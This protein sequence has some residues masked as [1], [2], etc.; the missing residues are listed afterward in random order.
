MDCIRPGRASSG[1][2]LLPKPRHLAV[3]A[4]LAAI[5][6]SGCREDNKYVPPPPAQVG[7]ATPLRQAVTPYLEVTGSV[8]AYD[9]VNL[10]ARVEGFLSQINYEDDAVVKRGQT[11]FVIEPTPYEA[12][13]KQAQASL[14]AAQAALV[15]SQAEFKRQDT[16]LHQNVT[17]EATLDTARAKRDGDQANVMSQEAGLT[18]AGVNLGYTHVAAPFDGVVTKHLQSVGELV[19]Q[20]TPT[21]LATIVQL[22]PIY[23]LFNVSEQDVLRLRQ[24]LVEHRLMLEQIKQI[25]VEIGLMDEPDYPHRGTLDY[26]SPTLDPATATI[27]V[28]GIFKNA[29]RALLPGFFARVRVPTGPPVAGALLVPDIAIGQSQEGRSLLVVNADSVV[30]QRAVQ[31]GQQVGTLRVITAG[32]KPEDRVVVTGNSRAVPGRRVAATATQI[33]ADAGTPAARPAAPAPL[34]AQAPAKP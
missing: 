10:V 18:L 21:Q 23:V 16:L 14:A 12:K 33:V 5:G 29:D 7:V 1:H 24:N 34:P 4:T 31:V 17:A 28:R 3:F 25:P 20:A 15:Q 2:R 26:I 27:Q 19:G 6:V 8:Q 9:S 30:E 13:Y 11:L 32:L 22:D